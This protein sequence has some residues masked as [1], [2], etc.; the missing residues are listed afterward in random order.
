MMDQ[1]DQLEEKAGTAEDKAA[2]AEQKVEEMAAGGG[3]TGTGGGGGRGA[4]EAE[5]GVDITNG[6]AVDFRIT[7]DA[8]AQADPDEFE[9]FETPEGVDPDGQDARGHRHHHAE[10]ARRQRH[11][12]DQAG[13]RRAVRDGPRELP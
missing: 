12:A 10:P 11:A 4:T 3:G 6:R 13:R 1:V 8:E 2:A 7:T 5:N 9:A